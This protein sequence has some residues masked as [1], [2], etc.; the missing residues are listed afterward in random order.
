MCFSRHA[1]KSETIDVASNRA[2]QNVV[3]GFGPEISAFMAYQNSVN[4][5]ARNID[6]D[7]SKSYRLAERAIS[8]CNCLSSDSHGNRG[9][10]LRF[11]TVHSAAIAID[12]GSD[13]LHRSTL[14]GGNGRPGSHRMDIQSY[15]RHPLDYHPGK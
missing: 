6:I 14:S 7:K 12:E 4:L 1:Q 11:S 9:S 5:T 2:L 15:W 8:S 3:S 10:L 13:E